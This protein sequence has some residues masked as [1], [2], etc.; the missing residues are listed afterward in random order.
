M[1]TDTQQ[2]IIVGVVLIALALI[3]VGQTEGGLS[4]GVGLVGFIAPKNTT[5]SNTGDE[6]SFR[7]EKE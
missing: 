6:K 7:G 1:R 5:S 2:I 4:L 3:C